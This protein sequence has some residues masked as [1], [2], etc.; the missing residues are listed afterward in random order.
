MTANKK[1]LVSEIRENIKYFS[2]IFYFACALTML[3]ATT[4]DTNDQRILLMSI[5]QISIDEESIEI[6]LSIINK[7]NESIRFGEDGIRSTFNGLTAKIKE[8]IVVGQ[9]F[10]PYMEFLSP[11]VHNNPILA[12]LERREFKMHCHRFIIMENA[13]DC[14]LR[15]NGDYVLNSTCLCL[16]E[17]TKGRL[18]SYKVVGGGR[19]KIVEMTPKATAQP[20]RI[21]ADKFE[22]NAAESQPARRTEAVLP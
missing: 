8:N 4:A 2:G 14:P 22:R 6:S 16:A 15:H 12:P 20:S 5:T 11:P 9:P 18:S 1:P 7:S 13:K 10:I 17:S 3:P 19:A 21:K